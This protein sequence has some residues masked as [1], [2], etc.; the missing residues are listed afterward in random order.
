MTQLLH[1]SLFSNFFS[2]V[3]LAS[4]LINFEPPV[5][6]LGEDAEESR[7]IFWIL[8]RNALFSAF[9]CRNNLLSVEE[10]DEFLGESDEAVFF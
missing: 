4:E 6:F 8:T 2:T 5:L 7:S 1:F 3:P 10:D 9:K